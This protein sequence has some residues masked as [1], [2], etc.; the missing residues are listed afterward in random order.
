MS[1]GLQLLFFAAGVC[2]TLVV[3]SARAEGP[4]PPAPRLEVETPTIDLGQVVRGRT[5]PVVFELR[6]AGDAS[7]TILGAK[8]G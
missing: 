7:L 2:A 4:P 3:G 1:K 8:P 6:N 5:E